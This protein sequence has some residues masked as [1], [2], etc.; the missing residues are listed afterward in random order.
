MFSSPGTDDEE[1]HTIWRKR[2]KRAFVPWS[3]NISNMLNVND[4]LFGNGE[5]PKAEIQMSF[6]GLKDTGLVI[7]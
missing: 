7:A 6:P 1:L 3:N 2:G 5:C 4:L